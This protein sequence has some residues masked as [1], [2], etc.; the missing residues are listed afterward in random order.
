MVAV[1]PNSKL[2][3]FDLDGTLVDSRRDI[4]GA[5]IHTLDRIGIDAPPEEDLYPHIGRLLFDIFFELIGDGDRTRAEEATCLYREYFYEHC[6]IHS[7]LYDGVMETLE[8]FHGRCKTA[9]ATMKKTFMAERVA[10]LLGLER[11]LDFVQG[12]DG[13]PGK[14]DPEV[15][16]R[17]LGRFG[18]R[19]GE[20]WMVGDSV[21]DILAGRRAGVGTV[22]VTYGIGER[23]KLLAAGPDC[24]AD[25]FSDLTEI[26]PSEGKEWKWRA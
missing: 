17:L 12:T 22:A 3:I 7:R 13:F 10:D 4:A 6:N 20:A 15:I 14:P 25:R 1:S 18:V 26:I 5:I 24:C 8:R 2:I 9:V 21:G 19:P 16:N 23:E 11:H